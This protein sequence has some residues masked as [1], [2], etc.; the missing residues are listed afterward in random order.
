[1][2]T[3]FLLQKESGV[4]ERNDPVCELYRGKSAIAH[5]VYRIL[6]HMKDKS[7]ESSKPDLNILFI[8]NITFRGIAKMHGG[9]VSMKMVDGLLLIVNGHFFKGI[10]KFLGGF[11][12]NKKQP[13][14]LKLPFTQS[15]KSRGKNYEFNTQCMEKFQRQ[16]SCSHAVFILLRHFKRCY[17]LQLVLMPL[18][19]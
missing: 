18:F 13:D 14:N 7:L 3:R 17:T 12:E 15:T 4:L 8:C 19:K 5:A 10:G 16:A 1:M 9:A 6:T 2:V 11:V